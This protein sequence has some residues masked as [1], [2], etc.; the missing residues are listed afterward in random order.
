M[1][2]PSNVTSGKTITKQIDISSQGILHMGSII[3]SALKRNT[4]QNMM[5]AYAKSAS[6]SYKKDTTL[7]N[8][9]TKILHSLVLS[10]YFFQEHHKVKAISF[11]IEALHS[12][13]L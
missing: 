12:L 6:L 9:S 1:D 3:L 5:D 7:T 2:R 13:N 11:G 10:H 8:T 4:T